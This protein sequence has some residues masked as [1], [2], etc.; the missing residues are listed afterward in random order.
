[1]ENSISKNLT[2]RDI[3]I[4]YRL[5]AK[6]AAHID[7]AGSALKRPRSRSDYARAAALYL[8][9]HQVPEPSKPIRLPPRRLPAA[10]I[11]LLCKA[12]GTFGGVANDI[13]EL[14]ALAKAGEVCDPN[15]LL[16]QLSAQMTELRQALFQALLQSPVTVSQP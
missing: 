13:G 14:L 2:K 8:A 4:A 9:R 1:M 11:R 10:D 15:Q 6:E 7:A 12:L 5:T 3:V 16:G